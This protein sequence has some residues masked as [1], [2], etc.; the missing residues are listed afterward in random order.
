MHWISDLVGLNYSIK[1]R[2]TNNFDHENINIGAS[3]FLLQASIV[4]QLGKMIL[5]NEI[6]DNCLSAFC[7]KL[8]FIWILKNHHFNE[9]FNKYF[10]EENDDQSKDYNC[11]LSQAV[12]R[13]AFRIGF[14]WMRFVYRPKIKVAL[15]TRIKVNEIRVFSYML[16]LGQSFHSNTDILNKRIATLGH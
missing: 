8:L 12:D 10:T 11:S 4:S 9:P 7:R 5:N 1:L 15:K 13:A 3:H 16:V 2:F 14:L 6:F